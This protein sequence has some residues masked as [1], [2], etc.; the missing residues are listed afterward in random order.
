[1]VFVFVLCL[2]KYIGIE[3]IYLNLHEIIL[4]VFLPG[5][6]SV[7]YV[8]HRY[9]GWSTATNVQAFYLRQR[10]LKTWCIKG[11]Y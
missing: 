8:K 6:R 1:M 3:K 4:T 5:I 7:F 2:D 9:I 11:L 10:E